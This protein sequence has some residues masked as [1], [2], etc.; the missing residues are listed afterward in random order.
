MAVA[1]VTAQGSITTL[2]SM[3]GN[4]FLPKIVGH[5]FTD[6]MNKAN[7]TLAAAEQNRTKGYFEKKKMLQIE[8]VE[9]FENLSA[10]RKSRVF[11]GHANKKRRELG[12]YVV[13]KELLVTDG[14]S[15]TE[16]AYLIHSCITDDGDY[17]DAQDNNRFVYV[18]DMPDG[19]VARS[20]SSAGKKAG[21]AEK[22]DAGLPFVSLIITT[23]PQ[24]V[25]ITAFPVDASYLTG[26][27]KL[28]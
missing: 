11:S 20:M 16:M 18:T 3:S 2:R 4:D 22:K 27:A 19:F 10:K 25:I 28:T 15:S 24:P 14:L 1:L 6:H 17:Y 7:A 12:R 13:H 26:K 9:D 8:S 5:A 23:D 21:H